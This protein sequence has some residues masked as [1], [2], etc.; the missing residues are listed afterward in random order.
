MVLV[1]AHL[2]VLS[3]CLFF[4]LPG[5]NRPI[6]RSYFYLW[7][8]GDAIDSF[9]LA[10]SYFEQHGVRV[11]GGIFNRFPASGFYSLDKCLESLQLYFSRS[12]KYI[13]FGGLSENN[14]L[15][16][17]AEALGSSCTVRRAPKASSSLEATPQDTQISHLASASSSVDLDATPEE[18]AAEKEAADLENTRVQSFL[19]YFQSQFRTE[20]MLLALQRFKLEK[21]PLS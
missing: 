12:T 4:L 7:C 20:Q 18:V 17:A 15:K 5:F 1:L 3:F 19:G 21:E 14:A 16:D 11:L 8:I 13:F 6:H 9:N 10:A 2:R